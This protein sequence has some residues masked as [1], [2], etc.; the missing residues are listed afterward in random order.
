MRA[1]P[2]DPE[3]VEPESY[4]FYVE[5]VIL[6]L[7]GTIYLLLSRIG[8]LSAKKRRPDCQHYQFPI[9]IVEA[10]WIKNAVFLIGYPLAIIYSQSCMGRFTALLLFIDILLS[11]CWIPTEIFNC[12]HGVSLLEIF[13]RLVKNFFIAFVLITWSVYGANDKV[14]TY[15]QIFTTIVGLSLFFYGL[16]TKLINYRPVAFFPYNDSQTWPGRP[17]FENATSPQLFGEAVQWIAFHMISGSYASFGYACYK[18]LIAYA[19]AHLRHEWY[20][21]NVP[22]YPRQR[23]MFIPRLV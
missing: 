16:R 15:S 19:R 3:D 20:L 6:I 7:A 1:P 23:A 12:H 14:L 17:D 5:N 18:F 11:F 13:L 4:V 2:L 8:L 10:W 21:E 9:T 22:D